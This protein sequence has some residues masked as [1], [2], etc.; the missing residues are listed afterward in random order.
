MLFELSVQQVLPATG[1]RRRMV[2]MFVFVQ[3]VSVVLVTLVA[4]VVVVNP[5]HQRANFW[6]G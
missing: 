6:G 2:M 1:P 4:M 3:S 5:Q